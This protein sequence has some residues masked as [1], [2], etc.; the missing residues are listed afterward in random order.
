MQKKS[1]SQETQQRPCRS[2]GGE[3]KP[4]E[5]YNDILF[6]HTKP[7]VRALRDRDH[8]V[9]RCDSR[10][11]DSFRVT[12]ELQ[13]VV[14]EHGERLAGVESL[15]D[16]RSHV[17]EHDVPFLNVRAFPSES[18]YN[19][20]QALCVRRCRRRTR[21]RRVRESVYARSESQQD[22]C[23]QS[24]SRDRRRHDL[25]RVRERSSSGHR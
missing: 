18:G 19:F 4:S 14:L 11:R 3:T 1:G 16:P 10:R 25:S 2:G 5:E 8:G 12:S 6:P 17:H 13:N 15:D 9:E 20:L 22:F 24:H 7:R 21:R 23:G